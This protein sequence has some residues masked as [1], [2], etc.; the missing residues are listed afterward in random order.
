[1]P[2]ARG[3]GEE[4]HERDGAPR[5]GAH[6][7]EHVGRTHVRCVDH[8]KQHVDRRRQIRDAVRRQGRAIF[9]QLIEPEHEVQPPVP[10]GRRNVDE[11]RAEHR[12]IVAPALD[13][14]TSPFG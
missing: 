13:R 10:R 8:P 3:P 2:T 4:V 12:R 9:V 6:V 1:M 5:T 11:G 7:D 14:L